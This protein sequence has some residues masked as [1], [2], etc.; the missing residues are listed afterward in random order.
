MGQITI[1]EVITAGFDPQP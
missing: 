1:D